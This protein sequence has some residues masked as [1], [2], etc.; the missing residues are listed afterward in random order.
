[1]KLEQLVEMAKRTDWKAEELVKAI[2]NAWKAAKDT[3]NA[4]FAAIE[5][6]R[7]EINFCVVEGS[8]IGPK[9]RPPMAPFTATTDFD[10][11]SRRQGEAI[12]EYHFYLNRELS[13]NEVDG[14]IDSI[15]LFFK[16]DY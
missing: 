16:P 7:H 6:L 1:M 4:S 14:I 9:L 12:H 15:D 13:Q 10:N 11:K 5:I 8:T 3:Y 2:H